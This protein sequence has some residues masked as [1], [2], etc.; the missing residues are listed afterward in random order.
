MQITLYSTNC[1]KC[2]VLEKK[3]SQKGYEFEIIHDVKE[4]RKKGYLT[5]PLLEVNGSIMDFAKANEW[6]NSQEGK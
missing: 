1:P 4:I 3:L 2:L 5:A 6:I